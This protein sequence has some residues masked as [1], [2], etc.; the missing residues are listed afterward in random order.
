LYFPFLTSPKDYIRVHGQDF[1]FIWLSRAE[2]A[3]TFIDDVRAFAPQAR[4][5][6]DT[7]DLHYLRL[8]RAAA[9]SADLSLSDRA[10]YMRATEQGVIK[11]ADVTLVRS[12]YEQ[13]VLEGDRLAATVLPIMREA[14]GTRRSYQ[15]RAN[16]G[17]IGGFAHPPNA[18][19]VR[20]FITAI[21]PLVRQQ[22]PDCKLIIAGSQMPPDLLAQDS[23]HI[24]AKGFVEDARDFFESIRLSIAPLRYGAGLKGK[25]IMSLAM[26]VP[27]VCSEIAAEGM[28]ASTGE[29]L[30]VAEQ[31]TEWANE[32]VRLYLSES[33]WSHMSDRGVA[34]VGARFSLANA[35]RVLR[36]VFGS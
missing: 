14:I 7:V 32:I 29:G 24:V 5:I 30:V 13:Q 8:R 11:R 17:F 26:G 23:S 16:I 36:G 22:L 18:D 35:E 19:A 4:V 27:C 20:Y 28:D 33:R 34:L 31:P 2:T 6:F 10:E 3:A 15:Q 25:V 9:F 12:T 21:W 1:D